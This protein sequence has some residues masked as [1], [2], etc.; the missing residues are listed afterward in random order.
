M[1][2]LIL[3]LSVVLLAACNDKPSERIIDDSVGGINGLHIVIDNELWK[4]TVGDTIRSLFAAPVDGLPQE[5]PLFTLNQMPESAFT[6]FMR[7]NRIYL[8]VAQADSTGFSMVENVYAKPQ[9]G[10]IITGTTNEEIIN[11]L[12]E[13]ADDIIAEFK[14][15][16]IKE[17]QRRISLSLKD[18]ELLKKNLGVS[19]K[20]P[21][22]YRYAKTEDDFFWIRKDIQNG[23][24]NIIAYEVPLSVIDKDTSRIAN[25]VRMRDSI[26][27]RNVTVDEGGRF[28]TEAAYFPYIFETNIDG[29]FA[30][31]T[32][33]TWEVLNKYMAGPFVN[34]AIRDEENNRYV[35]LEGF[36]FAPNVEKRDNMF[37]LESILRSAKIN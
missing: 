22:A 4:G 9:T 11:L 13:H 28:I 30:Y 3:L 8:K 12:D 33:G 19:L 24:M 2:K 31:E 21:T 23:G 7:K 1:R 27:G 18:D 15:R 37:E 17:K 32:K 36:V 25:I 35:I 16:E 26:G 10:A 5:E 14:N 34:Y 29:K 6:D 20:F